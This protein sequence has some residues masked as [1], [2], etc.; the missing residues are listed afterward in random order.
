MLSGCGSNKI[1]WCIHLL[2]LT[3][4]LISIYFANTY[5]ANKSTSEQRISRRSIR[6]RRK[7]YKKKR[8]FNLSWENK[9]FKYVIVWFVWIKQMFEYMKIQHFRMLVFIIFDYRHWCGYSYVHINIFVYIR[10]NVLVSNSKNRANSPIQRILKEKRKLPKPLQ[11]FQTVE[12]LTAHSQIKQ[13]QQQHI[14]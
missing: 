5:K 12:T 7:W 10:G 6:K 4:W 8:I 11:Y 9:S 2:I 1:D 3:I 13:Q 14:K